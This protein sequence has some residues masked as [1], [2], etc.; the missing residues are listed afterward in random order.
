MALLAVLQLILYSDF[1]L[2]WGLQRYRRVPPYIHLQIH[3]LYH[4]PASL[5]LNG[6]GASLDGPHFVLAYYVTTP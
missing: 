3:N 1:F 5:K 6:H 2:K 4:S